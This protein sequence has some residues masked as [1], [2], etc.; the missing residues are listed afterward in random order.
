MVLNVIIDSQVTL[1]HFKGF[2]QFPNFSLTYVIYGNTSNLEFVKFV[3]RCIHDA[4]L[5]QKVTFTWHVHAMTS[6]LS[7]EF[8]HRNQYNLTL[9]S[10]QLVSSVEMKEEGKDSFRSMTG[11]SSR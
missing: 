10:L 4:S 9:T 2:V 11:K 7:E 1:I 5:L 3:Y 6:D 8:P